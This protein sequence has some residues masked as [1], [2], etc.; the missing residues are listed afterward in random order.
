MPPQ[1]IIAQVESHRE[2]ARDIFEK[3]FRLVEPAELHYEAGNYVSVRVADGKTPTVFRAY[4]F[5]SDGHDPRTF[6][7]IFKLFRAENGEE[8]RGSGFLKNLKIGDSAE[9][10]GPAGAGSFVPKMA[11][12]SP[13][14]LLGTGTG[15]AP[16]Y[17]VAT[18]LSR[19]QSPRP[20]KFFL[21]V[22]FAEEIFYLA[23]FEKLK[24][25]NPNFDFTVA[26]SRPSADFVGVSGRLTDVLAKMEIPKNLEVLI[27]GSEVSA[28][29][30]KN[31]LIEL[32][33]PVEKIDAE[34]Y[35]AV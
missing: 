20:I 12:G 31:K 18:K 22:S 15:I 6:K 19:E 21:G 2:L 1:K 8:G 27:C 26:V 7:I 30:I 28:A 14:W 9:F 23:E 29:G 33:V 13:L 24:T 34:G 3:T 5:A 10:F 35:G 16:L 32:G 25:E 11:D 17:A 4:T